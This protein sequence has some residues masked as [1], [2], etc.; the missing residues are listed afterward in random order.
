MTGL[1][2]KKSRHLLYVINRE[3]K[4]FV[5]FN[6]K[7]KSLEKKYVRSGWKAVEYQ[8][9]FFR[10]FKLV[11]LHY[12]DEK[13]YNLIK[14]S[15]KYNPR[16]SSLSTFIARLAECLVYEGFILEGIRFELDRDC[17]NG[18]Y[19]HLKHPLH[20]YDKITVKLL[21]DAD[22]RITREFEKVFFGENRYREDDNENDKIFYRNLF[23]TVLEMNLDHDK[24]KE[25]IGALIDSKARLKEMI[26]EW[27]FDRKALLGYIVEYLDPFE[28]VRYRDGIR[29]LH[30]Y[31]NMAVQIGRKAK[32]YPKYLRSMHD[33]FSANFDAYKK[34]YDEEQFQ[35]M[36]MPD[37][38]FKDKQFCIAL[39]KSTKDIIQEG[40]DLNHCVASYVEKI[41]KGKCIIIFLRKANTPEESLVTVEYQNDKIVQARGSY[42]RNLEEEE[43]KFLEKFCKAKK[44]KLEV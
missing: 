40:A 38:E 19:I 36:Q 5:R 7:T 42:N 32:K 16:C 31:Y 20:D 8:Y 34:E 6:L 30:D 24:S 10:G 27:K 15:R 29:T 23:S 4:K 12:E 9:D 25:L 1:L 41:L 43:M 11:D 33:I 35:K 37:L 21:K 18:N 2:L 26:N 22:Y 44:L 39:P 17:W 28:N 3:T 14:L 13:F